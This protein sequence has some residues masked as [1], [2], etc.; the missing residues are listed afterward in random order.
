M[1]LHNIVSG[2]I[3]QVNPF[4]T[5]M[6]Q[7]SIGYETLPSGKRVPLYAEAYPYEAQMQSLQYNDIQQLSSLS[8]QG[9]MR[10]LYLNGN[11]NG[12]VR[13][14]GKGGDLITLPDNTVWLVT[15]V[16]ENWAFKDGWVKV[17]V[18]LQDGS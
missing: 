13:A 11:W 15:L 5:V 7:A 1:N 17:A 9:Q 10:A 3:A 18:T 14:D 12:V 4:I 16:L 2:A 6:L 8:I